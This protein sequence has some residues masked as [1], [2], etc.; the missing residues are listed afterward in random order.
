MIS[1][2][3][4]IT[5][6]WDDYLESQ[7]NIENTHQDLL[8]QQHK[9]TNELEEH[10]NNSS[11]T[12]DALWK[13]HEGQK[14]HPDMANHVGR[15]DDAIRANKMPYDVD[16]HSG[17]KYDPRTRMNS[18]GIVHHPAFLSTSLDK[19]RAKSF[20]ISHMEDSTGEEA[21]TLHIIVPKG[22]P[23]AYL[24]AEKFPNPEEK[25]VLLPRGLKL[26]HIHTESEP[27]GPNAV[28]YIHHMEIVK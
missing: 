4:F 10:A 24:G 9:N 14:L 20:A 1:F 6:S 8:N 28:H 23:G 17:I 18:E 27:E 2:K 16:V 15:L 22:H 3:Q 13:R 26:K 19:D 25:E 7:A 12:N 11:E 5:E 21:H